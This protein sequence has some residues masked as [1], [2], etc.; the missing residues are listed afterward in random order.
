M[1]VTLDTIQSQA[2]G[3]MVLSKSVK[4]AAAPKSVEK[5]QGKNST[6][7]STTVSAKEETSWW[8]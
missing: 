2:T 6:K 7:S 3:A 8:R 5:G 1:V 4:E